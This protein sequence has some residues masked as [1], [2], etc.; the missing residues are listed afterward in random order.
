MLYDICNRPLE[1][2]Q[3]VAVSHENRLF[4]GYISELHEET[5][6]VDVFLVCYEYDPVSWLVSIDATMVA[7]VDAKYFDPNIR[8]HRYLLNFC[9]PLS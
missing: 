5:G 8:E 7:V 6:M 3:P 1:L 9:L 2:L 4:L